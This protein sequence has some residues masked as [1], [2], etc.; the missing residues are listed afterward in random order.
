M[1][2]GRQCIMGIAI[3][4][5]MSSSAWCAP[6]LK[7]AAT[8]FPLYDLV[9][10]VAGT[11]AAVILLVPPGASPHTAAFT[12]GTIRQLTGSR[13]I[14]V[15]GHGLDDWVVQLADHAGIT[16]TVVVDS[17]I[18]LRSSEASVHSHSLVQEHTMPHSVVDP[19]YWLAIPNAIL[20]VQSVVATLSELDPDGRQ[21]YA[22]RAI[23]YQQQLRATDDRMRLVL[24]DLPQRDI[25]FFHPAFAYFAAAYDLHIVA[26]FE[27]VPGRE[28]GPKHVAAFLQRV[29]RHRL[30][31]LFV[32]PQL[33]TGLLTSLARDLGV[34]LQELDPLGGSV[35]R[36]SYIAMMLFNAT[37]IAAA[38]RE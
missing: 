36:A 27:E 19:H 23:V 8:I 34:T 38:L 3:A 1:C 28:P 4:I 18:A 35:G 14:F 31:V 26:T 15:I 16:Q 9:R 21:E 2:I 12:P 10:Q 5:V 22:G 17:H 29:R 11:R 25:A 37:R 7:V 32:E 13:C 33:D 20:I 6:R 24:A 30:R